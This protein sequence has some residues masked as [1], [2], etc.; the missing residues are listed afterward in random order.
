MN[1]AKS[2][3]VAVAILTL[4]SSARAD[5]WFWWQYRYAEAPSHW[6]CGAFEARHKC[7]AFFSI[8]RDRCGCLV[9]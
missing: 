5:G 3:L 6:V 8:R 7:N 2:L 4:A 1:T 9:H